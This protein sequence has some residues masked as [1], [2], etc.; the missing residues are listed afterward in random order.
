MSLTRQ[1]LTSYRSPLETREGNKVEHM[2]THCVFALETS[3]GISI[4]HNDPFKAA[5]ISKDKKISKQIDP[6]G[7]CACGLPWHRP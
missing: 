2:M 1:M 3:E 4:H 7:L 6:M 5:A